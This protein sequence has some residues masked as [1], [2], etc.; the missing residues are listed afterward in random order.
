MNDRKYEI[1]L[2]IG[3][4]QGAN[5]ED[6]VLLSELAPLDGADYSEAEIEEI[7]A[8]YVFEW[9]QNYIDSWFEEIV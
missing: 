1:G 3:F 9:Q 5:R 2:S 6:T 8:R 4:G 7:L